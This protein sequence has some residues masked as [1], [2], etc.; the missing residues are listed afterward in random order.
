ML[1]TE[2]LIKQIIPEPKRSDLKDREWF[3]NDEI[4][5]KLNEEERRAVEEKLIEMLG[6]DDDSLIPETLVKMKSLNAVP[7]MLKKLAS[8]SDSFERIQW[9][10]FINEIKNGDDE[11]EK[12]A[13]EAFE[14]LEFIYEVH[15]DVFYN[16][17]KFNSPRIDEL[18]ETYT[19]HKDFLV[20]YHAKEVLSFNKSGIHIHNEELE[21]I[22]FPKK[23][24]GIALWCK[25]FKVKLSDVQLIAI[26]PRL[27]LDDESL[28]ILIVDKTG[29]VF[30]IPYSVLNIQGFRDLENYFQLKPIGGEWEKFEY[31]DHYGKCDKIIYPQKHYWKDLYKNDW[32][33]KVRQ[34]YSWFN[35]KSFFG[36]INEENR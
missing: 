3:S 7:A 18:I 13:F 15:G 12:V 4:L 20:A 25:S 35:P 24:L 11:M 1:N 29:A 8:K 19:N 36:N 31:E 22:A 2:Q 23:Q 27:V 16:L 32:K 33:L 26:S 28:F 5:T 30:P 10:T 17:I 34:L 14:K 21:F 6:S 9:A